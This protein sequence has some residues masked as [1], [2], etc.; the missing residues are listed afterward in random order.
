MAAIE[1]LN[2][3]DGVLGVLMFRPCPS[4]WTRGP[5][6]RAPAL[7]DVDA[8]RRFPGPV[9][10]GAAWAF[11]PNGPVGDGAPEYYGVEIA[12]KKAASS[13]AA[14]S[15]AARCPAA[16]GRRRHGDHVPYEYAD[17]PASSG[18]PIFCGRRGQGEALH[19]GFFTGGQTVASWINCPGRSRDRWRRGLDWREPLVSAITPSTAEWARTTAPCLRPCP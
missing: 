6:R 15:S 14:V 19:A 16:H 13:A 11:P 3:D 9:Y 1:A 18:R 7:E 12:G 5:L 10:A 17:M 4:R 8:S 2:Q